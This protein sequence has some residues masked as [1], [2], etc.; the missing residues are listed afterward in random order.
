MDA[1]T[2]RDH[3]AYRYG[4]PGTIN[5]ELAEDAART[6]AGRLTPEATGGQGLDSTGQPLGDALGDESAAL[7][8]L[9]ATTADSASRPMPMPAD[10]PDPGLNITLPPA[11]TAVPATSAAPDGRRTVDGPIDPL[12]NPLGHSLPAPAQGAR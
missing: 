3:G 5:P 1:S 8:E 6:L 11:T 2:D 12:V 10:V 7:D 9:S 4:A